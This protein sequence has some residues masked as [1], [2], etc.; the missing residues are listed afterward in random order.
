MMIYRCLTMPSKTSI[1]LIYR[2]RRTHNPILPN[3]PILIILQQPIHIRTLQPNKLIQTILLTNRNHPATSAPKPRAHTISSVS[4]P[5][6]DQAQ[7]SLT[8]SSTFPRSNTPS[9]RFRVNSPQ[10]VTVSNSPIWE[11]SHSY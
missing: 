1:K 7:Y 6:S 9:P 2:R 11:P 4:D 5:H 3:N 8:F 10:Y